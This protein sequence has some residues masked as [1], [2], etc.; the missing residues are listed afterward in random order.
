MFLAWRV[1]RPTN[2]PSMGPECLAPSGH[3]RDLDGSAPEATTGFERSCGAAGSRVPAT[4]RS[5]ESGRGG[6]TAT[7]SY[8]VDPSVEVEVGGLAETFARRA[9]VA[10]PASAGLRRWQLQ[11]SSVPA[12]GGRPSG[13][14]GRHRGAGL[15]R[16]GRHPVGPL[17]GA[18]TV[19]TVSGDA[20]T[21]PGTVLICT[22][23]SEFIE[24]YLPVV[25]ELRDARLRRRGLRLAWAGPVA[26]PAAQRPQGAC[27]A[28]SPTTRATFSPWPTRC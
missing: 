17:G 24:K 10:G 26:A 22:G 28:T 20:D 2:H 23:R 1:I 11:G 5:E 7:T 3:S 12:R 19:P 21:G 8:S 4:R 13:A 25:A 6:M 15:E 18:R 16:R 9:D 27:R 14:A